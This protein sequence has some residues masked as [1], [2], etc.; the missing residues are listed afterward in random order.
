MSYL[1]AP[2]SN[3]STKSQRKAASSRPR[4]RYYEVTVGKVQPDGTM[5]VQT[6]TASTGRIHETVA[7]SR[8]GK[9]S[10]A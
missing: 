8:R 5:Q 9:V 10:L 3:P 2:R 6:Y 1:D 4:R 7:V